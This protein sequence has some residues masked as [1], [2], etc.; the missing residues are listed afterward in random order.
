MRVRTSDPDHGCPGVTLK[1]A[2]NSYCVVPMVAVTPASPN[3]G[4]VRVDV[5]DVMVSMIVE[6]AAAKVG[7]SL[8]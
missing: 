1:V 2:L 7:R 8:A 6:S 3:T 5:C 4:G